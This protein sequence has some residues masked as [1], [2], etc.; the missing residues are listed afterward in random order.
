MNDLESR[1]RDLP[2]REPSA[3]LDERVMAQKPDRPTPET[4]RSRRV[5]VWLAAVTAA[6]MGV[7]GFGA[8][9]TWRGERATEIVEPPT[10]PPVT[11]QVIY[12]SPA[13]GDPF[14]FTQSSDVFPA[15]KMEEKIAIHEGVES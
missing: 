12:N 3:Q 15:G 11:I 5:P 10:Q 14:D 6:L 13:T 1:L 8:G 9:A 4:G 2:L 7:A